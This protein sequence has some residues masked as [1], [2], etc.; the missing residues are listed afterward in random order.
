MSLWRPKSVRT[1][2]GLDA[3][4]LAWRAEVGSR[5]RCARHAQALVQALADLPAGA[6]VDLVAGNDV[7]VHWLQTPPTS[8]AS[9][10]ELK[11]VA[12]ARC[13]H[14]YGGSPQDWWVTGDWSATE[15]FVCAALP[16][17]TISPIQ[18]ALDAAKV[19]VRWKT[20]WAAVCAAHAHTF[21]ADG[22]SALRSPA[23][24]MVWHCRQ[25][26]VDCLA[27]HGI[28]PDASDEGLTAQALQ[29]AQI[30][31]LRDA[32]LSS[33]SVHWIALPAEPGVNPSEAESALALGERLE[34]T[35]A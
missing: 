4:Q 24:M 15:P 2:W 14:L 6:G 30:Q 25:G 34:S 33:G 12:A 22:W 17:S 18:Q 9:L 21:P 1:A 27:T 26:R 19:Q 32:R 11:L 10:E 20:A 31:A 5:P 7:S 28:S 29:F 3:H 35:V 23:R 16:Y 8:V 13:A